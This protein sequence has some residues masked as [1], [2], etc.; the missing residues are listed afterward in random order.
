MEKINIADVI[1]KLIGYVIENKNC[2]VNIEV[3]PDRV[4]INIAPWEPYKIK[5]PY[6]KDSG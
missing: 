1:D 3:E 2:E 6:G 5:C 4:Q